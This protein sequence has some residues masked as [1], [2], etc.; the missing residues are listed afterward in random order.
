MSGLARRLQRA[1]ETLLVA[2]FVMMVLNVTWQVASR[3]LFR[4]PSA[5][6][7]EMARF[8]LI[9]LGLLGACLAWRRRQHLAIR[10]LERDARP[11][12]PGRLGLVATVLFGA[13]VLGLGGGRL[14]WLTALLGQRSAALGWPLAVVYSVVPLAGA[15]LVLFAA[16]DLWSRDRHES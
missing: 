8:L 4:S 12:A 14:V 5:W 16:T 1:L 6:T 7:E 3:F 15:I 9:W 10:V 13:G 2:L 11:G